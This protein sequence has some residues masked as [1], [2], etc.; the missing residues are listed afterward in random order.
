MLKYLL[1]FLLF[2][3]GRASYAECDSTSTYFLQL[4]DN[5]TILVGDSCLS[6][7]DITVTE[8][9][10]EFTPPSTTTSIRLRCFNKSRDV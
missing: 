1:T 7:N 9:Y 8:F 3:I 2:F 10:L 5:V 6:N 4:P